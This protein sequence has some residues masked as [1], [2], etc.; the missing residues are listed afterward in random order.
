MPE[1]NADPEAPSTPKKQ[2]DFPQKSPNSKGSSSSK[3]RKSPAKPTVDGRPVA[4]PKHRVSRKSSQAKVGAT[5]AE[6][7]GVYRAI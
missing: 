1:K 3:K 6:S 7:A 5:E 2:L 4:T